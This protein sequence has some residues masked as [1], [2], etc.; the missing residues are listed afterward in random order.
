MTG[1]IFSHGLTE[2]EREMKIEIKSRWND[3]ILFSTDAENIKDA[4]V[5]AVKSGAYLRGAY[6]VGAYLV[7]ANLGGADLGGADLVDAKYGNMPMTV[8]P[9][10]ISGLHWHVMMFDHHIKIGCEEHSID[11]WGNFSD[12]EINNMDGSALAFWSEWKDVI[13]KTARNHEPV[14]RLEE[15]A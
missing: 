4:V 7:D 3:S 13:I 5:E 11:E 15:T 8:E 10:Q 1:L 9:I 2:K 14:E 6:L 12:G